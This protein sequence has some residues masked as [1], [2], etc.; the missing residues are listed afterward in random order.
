VSG[1]ADLPRFAARFPDDPALG[2][3]VAAF[4][5]G[6][7]ARVHEGGGALLASGPSPEVRAAVLELQARTRPDPLAKLFFGL[8]A[9]LLVVL[10]AYWWWKAGGAGK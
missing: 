2:A 7:Y 5:R 6:D 1:G 4:A 8:P 9:V 10:S 3:L